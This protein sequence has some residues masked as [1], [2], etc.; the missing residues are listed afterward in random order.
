MARK[1]YYCDDCETWYDDLRDLGENE[2]GDPICP[3]CGNKYIEVWELKEILNDS[4]YYKPPRLVKVYEEEPVEIPG[5]EKTSDAI[6][7]F[8]DLEKWRTIKK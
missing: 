4:R 5:F 1:Q 2:N 3:K 8:K 6:R 7:A